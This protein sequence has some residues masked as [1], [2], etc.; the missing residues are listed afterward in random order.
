[1]NSGKDGLGQRLVKGL[2]NYAVPDKTKNA[3]YLRKSNQTPYLLIIKKYL[4]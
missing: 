2:L 3:P 4:N 1:M